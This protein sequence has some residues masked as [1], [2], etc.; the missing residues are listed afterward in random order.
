MKKDFKWR[1]LLV[2]EESDL[3]N[4]TD[5][6]YITYIC[7]YVCLL[8]EIGEVYFYVLQIY[9]INIYTMKAFHNKK[10]KV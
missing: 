7:K 10:S 6:A 1:I 9:D 8:Y 4:V 2:L 3:P 5:Q